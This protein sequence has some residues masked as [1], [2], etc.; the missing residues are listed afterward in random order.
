MYAIHTQSS[1]P[2]YDDF[3]V[4]CHT[5]TPFSLSAVCKKCA[6]TC[7]VD[8]DTKSKQISIIKKKNH[9]SSSVVLLVP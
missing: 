4:K 3:V 9:D 7:F 8:L 5:E 2:G 6:F 1:I